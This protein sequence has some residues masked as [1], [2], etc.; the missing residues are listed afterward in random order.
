[1]LLTAAVKA[2]MLW[3]TN[4]GAAAAGADAG[5]AAPVVAAAPWPACS[6]VVVM[7]EYQSAEPNAIDITDS[8]SAQTARLKTRWLLCLERRSD[9]IAS[10]A[11]AIGR[12]VKKA[13]APRMAMTTE[14]LAFDSAGCRSAGGG[15][16]GGDGCG[17]GSGFGGG[18]GAA[19]LEITSKRPIASRAPLAGSVIWTS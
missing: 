14:I 4:G 5:V 13:A 3:G 16:V 2:S 1:M 12:G 8:A 15:G 7:A 17:C 10:T 18:S 6:T 19:P 11:D 9:W